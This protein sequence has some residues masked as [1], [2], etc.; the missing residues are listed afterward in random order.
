MPR[1]APIVDVSDDVRNILSQLVNATTTSQRLAQRAQIILLAE[2][3]LYSIAIAKQVGLDR[4]QV[5]VWRARWEASQPAIEAVESQGIRAELRRTIEETL[6]DAPRPGSPGTFKPEQVTQ[7]IS[8]ACEDPA[9]SEL[10]ITHWTAAELVEVLKQR[11]IVESISVS[12]VGRYLAAA[13]LQPHRSQYWLTTT[14]KD[15]DVFQEQV[16]KVCQTYLAAPELYHKHNTRTVC[17]DEKTGIQALERTQKEIPMS[18]GRPARIEPEYIRHGTVCLIGNWDVVRG[19]MISPTLSPTRTEVDFCWH[20][21]DTVQTDPTAQWVFVMDRLN[22][23][24][25]A[26]LVRYVAGLEGISRNELGK[27]GVRGILKSMAT[28]RNFLEDASHRVRFVYPPK[29]SSW[30]NQIEPIFGILNRKALRRGSFKSVSEL[31][32]RI[33][34]FLEYFNATLGKPFDWTY[35]G[36]P[37]RTARDERPKTWKEAWIAARDIR[38]IAADAAA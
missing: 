33:E 7:V 35:T 5:G 17:V 26:A 10:P 29:H 21:H 9:L 28:R 16:E 18:H 13:M 11:G 20:I 1:T 8:L 37:V 34:D 23:H 38:N 15:Q 31:M 25:S 32:S 22:T 12:T 14:E 6:S 24:Q 36:R 3:R 4:R 2:A 19:Q 27:K 30:L